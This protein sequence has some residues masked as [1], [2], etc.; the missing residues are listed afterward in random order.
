MGLSGRPAQPPPPASISRVATAI[1]VSDI[2][3]EEQQRAR[4]HTALY[5]LLVWMEQA[6]RQIQRY[7]AHYPEETFDFQPAAR[8]VHHAA[9]QVRAR[10]A[11]ITAQ[12]R[13]R[14]H[15]ER[16]RATGRPSGK[17]W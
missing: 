4:Q 8:D 2:V 15:A 5:D 10:L 13:Q 17:L 1:I 9:S 12:Q 11:A 3:S 14:Q 7:L 16:T 6:E